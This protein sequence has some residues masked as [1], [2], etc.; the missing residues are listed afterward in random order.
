VDPLRL[1]DKSDFKLTHAMQRRADSLRTTVKSYS[2][3]VKEKKFLKTVRKER[4]EFQETTWIHSDRDIVC[5]VEPYR[6]IEIYLYIG[7]EDNGS[8]FLKMYTSYRDSRI[9]LDHE[10]RWIFYDRI[11]LVS[12]GVVSTFS[13]KSWDK[14]T[15]N[16]KRRL[17]EW[18]HLNVAHEEVKRFANSKDIKVR[19]EG[20]YRHDFKM[21]P[22]Q[23]LAFKDII[24]QY[25]LL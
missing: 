6:Y 21:T 16:N 24:Q 9:D 3:K 11:Y 4:D 20:E 18:A 19:F 12:N 22:G 14:K 8:K 25:E 10:V 5:E 13:I 1:P 17:K 15:E 2:P 23:L 7:I